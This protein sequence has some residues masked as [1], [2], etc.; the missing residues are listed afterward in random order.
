MKISKVLETLPENLKSLWNFTWK[1]RKSLKLYLR[2][3]KEL[4]AASGHLGPRAISL[5]EQKINCGKKIVKADIDDDDTE[6]TH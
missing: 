3:L 2:I 5:G 1:S 4:V 6:L